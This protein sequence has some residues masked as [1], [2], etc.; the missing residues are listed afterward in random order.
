MT[1]PKNT[2]EGNPRQ[3]YLSVQAAEAL[4]FM[5]NVYHKYII[6]D[7]KDHPSASVVIEFLAWHFFQTYEDGPDFSDFKPQT[8]VGGRE[9]FN[10]DKL[11]N[12]PIAPSTIRK[13]AGL[14]PAL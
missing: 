12:R 13:L 7:L 2:P 3:V 14:D 5:R 9:K 4:A 10:A 1:T 11:T 6:G 8:R